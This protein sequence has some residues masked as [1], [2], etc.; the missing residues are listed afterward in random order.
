MLGHME[1][2]RTRLV[3]LKAQILEF[4]QSLSA[5]QTEQALVQGRLNSYQYPVLT[6]PNE[7]A[8]EIFIHFLPIYPHPPPITGLYS[9]ICLTLVCRTWREVALSTPVLW[10]AI[11]ITYHRRISCKVQGTM[12]DIW[13]ARSGSCP[14]SIDIDN[15]YPILVSGHEVYT[16]VVAHRA[17]WEYLKLRIDDSELSVV[18]APMPLLHHLDLKFPDLYNLFVF[19][20]VPRL[21]SVVLHNYVSRVTL[22]WGQ[23]T[24]LKLAGTYPHQCV[25]ILQQTVNLVHCELGVFVDPSADPGPDITLPCLESL[26]LIPLGPWP[27][28]GYLHTFIV[29]AL[30]RLRVYLRFLD[31]ITPIASL[32]SF[33]SKSGCRLQE[34]HIVD[35]SALEQSFREGFPSIPKIICT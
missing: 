8:S 7:I 31:S 34:V 3:E 1:A 12:A 2:D 35:A 22:P 5:L 19:H 26:V 14:L 27:M 29:P 16:A 15:P 28:E 9:P 25:R 4:G 11:R 10:R 18:D 32:E 20:A 13:L 33:I 6:L 24:S 23:L 30:H 21:R 17:R